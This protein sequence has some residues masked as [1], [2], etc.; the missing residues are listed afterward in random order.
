M[1]EA[2][3]LCDFRPTCDMWSSEA[4]TAKSSKWYN[5]LIYILGQKWA[6]THIPTQAEIEAV[7]NP[8]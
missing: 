8:I 3:Y 5:E 7:I 6:H 2:Y 4:N 1:T